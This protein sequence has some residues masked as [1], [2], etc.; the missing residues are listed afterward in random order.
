[1]DIAKYLTLILALIV[2]TSISIRVFKKTASKQSGVLTGFCINALLLSVATIVF[3]RLLNVKEVEGFFLS[4]GILIFAFFIP[5]II[6][7]NFYIIQFVNR[8]IGMSNN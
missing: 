3:Y 7:I 6:L 2:S 1:M 8:K 4:L 5:I